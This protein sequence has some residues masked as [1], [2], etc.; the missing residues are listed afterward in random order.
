MFYLLI[1]KPARLDEGDIIIEI[2]FAT[3]VNIQTIHFRSYFFF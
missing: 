1:A 2:A 3:Q